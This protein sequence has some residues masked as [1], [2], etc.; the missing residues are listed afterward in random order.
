MYDKE[1]K[2]LEIINKNSS[3]SQRGIAAAADISIGKANALIKHFLLKNYIRTE[4]YG[5]KQRYIV[6]EIGLSVLEKHIKGTVSNKIMIS[7]IKGKNIKTAVI[8]AA[9]ESPEFEEPVGS[10]MLGSK[11]VIERLTDILKESGIEKIIIIS[12]YKSKYYEKLSNKKDI[13]VIENSA[14]K[15]S[16]TMVSLALAKDYIDDDFLLVEGDV[17][18][19]KRGITEVLNQKSRDCI[20][21]TDESGSGDEVFV[22]IRNEFLFK[23]SKDRHQFNH[24]HG[25][26][27]GICKISIDIYKKMLE[28]FKNNS[29]PYLNY[30]YMLF[31]IARTYNIGYVKIKD[32]IWSEID[33]KWHYKNLTNYIYPMI[34]KRENMRGGTNE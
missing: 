32:L 14:Y 26:M 2:V 28:E 25:E 16:G 31:D 1:L 12:G 33:T 29:N 20:L 15:A 24:I 34:E 17:V 10:L 9:G 5:N 11:T 21:I 4:K 23:M 19:E 18:I 27:I 22:E 3:I 13:F 8:L 7:G 6:T 30:E